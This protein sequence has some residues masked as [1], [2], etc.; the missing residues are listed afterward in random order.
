M[1]RNE[2]LPRRFSEASK[3]YVSDVGGGS[4]VGV[5][6][7]LRRGRRPR[8]PALIVWGGRGTSLDHALHHLLDLLEARLETVL[9]HKNK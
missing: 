7:V 4:G 8:F 9:F 6:L 1:H 3:V 2:V 5:C